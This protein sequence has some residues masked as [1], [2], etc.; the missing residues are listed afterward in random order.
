MA[1]P[2]LSKH[3]H[4]PDLAQVMRGN[5]HNWLF[6]NHNLDY[7]FKVK[8]LWGNQFT[9]KSKYMYINSVLSPG[10]I[11]EQKQLSLESNSGYLHSACE[12]PMHPW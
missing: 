6:E 3:T 1:F 11:K 10:Y 12:D 8:V 5:Y 7:L 2:S 9:C 4:L